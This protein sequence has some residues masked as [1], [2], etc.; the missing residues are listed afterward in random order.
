MDWGTIAALI[1]AAAAIISLI[2]QFLRR[3]KP[4]KKITDDHNLRISSIELELK[5]INESL[6]QVRNKIDHHDERD[7]KDFERLENK[8]EKFADLIIQMIRNEKNNIPVLKHTSES[9][10]KD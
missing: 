10:K 8:I 9:N 3:D 1:I 6:N 7:Q 5:H 4:W 2:I